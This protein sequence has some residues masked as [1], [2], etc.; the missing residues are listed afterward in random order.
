MIFGR[1]EKITG[2]VGAAGA[3]GY[4]S[5]R[6][7]GWRLS[8]ELAAWRTPDGNISTS[9]RTCEMP[10][11]GFNLARKRKLIQPYDVIEVEVGGVR[12]NRITMIRR[13]LLVDVADP[14]LQKIA[15]KLREPIVLSDKIIGNLAYDR[16]SKAYSGIVDWCSCSVT[17]NLE[18]PVPEDYEQVLGL[19]RLLMEDQKAWNSRVHERMLEELLDLANDWLQE[20]DTTLPADEFLSRVRLDSIDLD[21]AGRVRFYYD[22]GDVFAGHFIEVGGSLVEGVKWAQISG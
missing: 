14:E 9:A 16:K 20:P 19:A 22:D 21:G 17:I 10:V 12:N 5:D 18:C 15:G 7:G 8:F 1:R 2:V 3:Q 4:S 11:S 6:S 13:V